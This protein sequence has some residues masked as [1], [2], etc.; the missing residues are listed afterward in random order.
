MSYLIYLQTTTI[1]PQSL[2][3]RMMLLPLLPRQHLLRFLSNFC[4]SNKWH[5][6]SAISFYQVSL[7]PLR[8]LKIFTALVL[9]KIRGATTEV[10]KDPIVVTTTIT[11]TEDVVLVEVSSLGHLHKT[12][13]MVHA[14]YMTLDIFLQISLITIHLPFAI[15]Q[16]PTMLMCSLDQAPQDLARGT[17][18]QDPTVL[19][20][21]T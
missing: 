20:H 11:T 15:V 3:N 2:H 1:C 18:I 17:Q 21:R 6:N 12:P 19:K 10:D 13:C 5:L 9:P 4:T 16:I 7:L 8:L 14:T